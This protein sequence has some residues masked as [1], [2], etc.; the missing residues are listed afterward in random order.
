MAVAGG[1]GMTVVGLKGDDID[2]TVAHPPFGDQAIGKAPDLGGRAPQD[3]R[4]EAVFMIQMAVH[5]GD[6]EIVVIV[7][8]GREAFREFPLVVIEDVGQTGD[9]A[10]LG[11]VAAVAFDRAPNEIAY[12]FRTIAVASLRDQ[13]IELPGEGFVEGNGKAFHGRI[14]AQSWAVENAAR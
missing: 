5:G 3:H 10:S 6:R 14:L 1:V 12:R 13:G 2:A 9:A 11:V 4:F 7:L 8:E